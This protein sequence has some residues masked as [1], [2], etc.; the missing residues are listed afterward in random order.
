MFSFMNIYPYFK[1]VVTYLFTEHLILS[2]ENGNSLFTFLI[3]F[4]ICL[5]DFGDIPS[6][7]SESCEDI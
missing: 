5:Q 4:F 7:F 1:A 2:L 3:K 6:P